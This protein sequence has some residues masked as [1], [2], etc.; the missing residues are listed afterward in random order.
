MSQC[1]CLVLQ[2]WLELIVHAAPQSNAHNSWDYQDKDLYFGSNRQY[3]AG[4]LVGAAK[5]TAKD[6]VIY[7]LICVIYTWEIVSYNEAMAE[8]NEGKIFIL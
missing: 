8:A 4:Q 1:P 6:I 2:T 5:Q 3:L 7:M